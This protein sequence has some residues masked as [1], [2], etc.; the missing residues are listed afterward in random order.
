MN[1]ILVVDDDASY[2]ELLVLTLQDQCGVQ[3]VQGFAAGSLLLDHLAR[4]GGAP[5][6]VLLDL[7]MAGIS[8]LDLMREVRRRDERVPIAFLSGAASPDERNACLAEGAVAFLTKPVAYGE[9]VRSL[10]AL[11]RDPS[12]SPPQP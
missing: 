2:L 10:Q 5:G 12:L 8:G 6:L 9:L 1:S 3:D 7:H 4:G 11:V